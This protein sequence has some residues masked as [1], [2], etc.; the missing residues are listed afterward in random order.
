MLGKRVDTTIQGLGFRLVLNLQ[1]RHAGLKGPFEEPK[2]A[3]LKY[4]SCT[5]GIFSEEQTLRVRP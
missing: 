1:R 3:L 5:A 4:V 2:S